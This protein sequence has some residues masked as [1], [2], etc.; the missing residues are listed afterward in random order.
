MKF[1]KVESQARYDSTPILH[2]FPN[3]PCQF[4]PL[5]AL[6]KM[7]H[8]FPGLLGT[9]WSQKTGILFGLCSCQIWGFQIWLSSD[10]LGFGK[11]F[12]CIC[13]SPYGHWLSSEWWGVHGSPSSPFDS[14]KIAFWQIFGPFFLWWTIRLRED[15]GWW[16]L[17]WRRSLEDLFK[18]AWQCDTRLAYTKSLSSRYLST[19]DHLHG[20]SSP[21][22]CAFC[23]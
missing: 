3:L 7:N 23:V 6:S 11:V 16:D 10:R 22:P 4:P 19:K 21:W 1:Q 13:S 14:S 18:M 8:F 15:G 9:S 5:P 20:C 12:L 2:H 17:F